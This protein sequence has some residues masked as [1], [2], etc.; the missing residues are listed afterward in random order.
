MK[1]FLFELV[2]R[3]FA[4]YSHLLLSYLK[5]NPR[6][7]YLELLK[8]NPEIVRCVLHPGGI[9]FFDTLN[10]NRLSDFL[11]IRVLEEL[12]PSPYY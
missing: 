1:D 6:E 3:R 9:F 2:S 10:K 11:A 5:N 12:F 8:E 7:R 4:H